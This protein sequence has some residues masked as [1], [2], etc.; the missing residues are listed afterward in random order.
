MGAGPVRLLKPGVGAQEMHRDIVGF[1]SEECGEIGGRAS[2]IVVL[3]ER[4]A[5][6]LKRCGIGGR[7]FERARE[8]CDGRREIFLPCIGRCA[9]KQRVDVVALQR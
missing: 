5:A 7:K 3:Q 2:C 6:A 1:Q 8:I 4:Y 9:L